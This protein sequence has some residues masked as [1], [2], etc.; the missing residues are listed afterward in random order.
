MFQRW[1]SLYGQSSEIDGQGRV[2]IHP[3]LRERAAMAGDVFVMPK[4]YVLETSARVPG[5][6]VLGALQRCTRVRRTGSLEQ[7]WKAT[8]S[9]L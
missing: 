3:L 1:T 6:L 4:A 9:A 5:S 7:A 2:L 8:F